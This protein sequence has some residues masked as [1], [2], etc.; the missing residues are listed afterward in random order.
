MMGLAPEDNAR[1]AARLMAAQLIERPL[2]LVPGDQLGERVVAA[3]SK[4]WPNT[5]NPAHYSDVFE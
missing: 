1:D 2:L 4:Q 3:Y 5:L